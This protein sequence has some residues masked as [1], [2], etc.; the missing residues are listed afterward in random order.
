[1]Q[2][3]VLATPATGPMLSSFNYILGLDAM[4]DMSTVSIVG[5]M[6]TEK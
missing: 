3:R 6:L 5:D 4:V 2:D 1:M